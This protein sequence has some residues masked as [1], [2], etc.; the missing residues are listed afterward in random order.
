MTPLNW[1]LKKIAKMVL[2]AFNHNEK[3]LK[4]QETW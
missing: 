1:T 4:E 3:L 2:H